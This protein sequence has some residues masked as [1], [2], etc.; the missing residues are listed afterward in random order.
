ML[1][2]KPEP[3]RSK[4]TQPGKARVGEDARTAQSRPLLHRR[5]W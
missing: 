3:D 5:R 2:L 4:P 1:K